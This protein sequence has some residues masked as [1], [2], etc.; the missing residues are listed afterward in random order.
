[1]RRIIAVAAVVLIAAVPHPAAYASCPG[2]L[3]SIDEGFDL[4]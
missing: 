1:M 3:P 2:P 4:A